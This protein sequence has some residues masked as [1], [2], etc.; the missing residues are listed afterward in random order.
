MNA[1]YEQ[2]AH[3][4]TLTD[5]QRQRARDRARQTLAARLGGEPQYSDFVRQAH[6][7]YGPWV[8]RFGLLATVI[9]LAAAFTISAIHIF[10]V[11]VEVTAQAGASLAITRIVGV[12]FV[13]LAESALITFSLVPTLWNMPKRFARAVSVGVAAGALI[14]IIGNVHATIP[15]GDSAFDWLK[16]WWAALATSP[17][18][19]ALATLPPLIV[20]LMGMGLKYLLLTSS[21]QRSE[22]GAAYRSALDDWNA[23][24]AN[25]EG[26]KQWRVFWFNAL[27]DEWV[28]ENG[29]R[30]Q[31]A[32]DDDTKLAIV[33]REME[34]EDRIERILNAGARGAIAGKL[35]GKSD[36]TPLGSRDDVITF[37]RETPGA[38]SLTGKEIAEITGASEAT[39][40]RARRAFS[41]NGHSE[42]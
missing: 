28:R 25:I 9:V 32:V 38:E 10:T 12:S 40:S 33:L 36:E 42:K 7:R 6:S 39:V 26:H 37:L 13:V 5:V 14:A 19:W 30:M 41:S 4:P 24:M 3:L 20:V 31:Y 2:I 27:W 15:Y 35:Q 17:V 16:A 18:A 23:L 22:A 1:S 8:M 21:E 11:G 34:A 29:S